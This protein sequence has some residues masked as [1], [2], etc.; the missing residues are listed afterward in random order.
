MK[1]IIIYGS[2]YGHAAHYA[3]ELAHQTGFDIYNHLR[4][5]IDYE[6]IKLKHKMMMRLLYEKA[7]RMPEQDVTPEI[8]SMI[9]TYGQLVDFTALED[10]NP[11]IRTL[12]SGSQ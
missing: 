3:R 12:T 7:K 1:T 11:I 6:N 8:R 9:D 4:G 5:G 2:L 10:L